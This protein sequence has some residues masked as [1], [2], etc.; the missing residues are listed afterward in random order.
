MLMISLIWLNCTGENEHSI[1]AVNS[2]ETFRDVYRTADDLIGQIT[3]GF[4][5]YGNN[6]N[7]VPLSSLKHHRDILDKQID[8]FESIESTFLKFSN[9]ETEEKERLDALRDSRHHFKT[10]SDEAEQTI[11]LLKEIA[12]KTEK[13]IDD[14]QNQFEP[15]KNLVHRRIESFK[16]NIENS[17]VFDLH[18]LLGSLTTLAF[19]Q[20]PAGIAIAGTEIVYDISENYQK[21]EDDR[22]YRVKKDYLLSKMQKL[23]G[24]IV[25][26][27]DLSEKTKKLNNG[28]IQI[29]K[30]GS[31]KLIVEEKNLSDFLDQFSYKFPETSESL[32]QA[33]MDYVN[34]V[35]ARNEKI[36]YYNNV[37]TLIIKNYNTIENLNR[38]RSI[39]NEENLKRYSPSLPAF[40]TLMNNIYDIAQ[41]QVMERLYLTERAFLFWG[42][43][44]SKP[45]SKL[46]SGC[47]IPAINCALL[48]ESQSSI[49]SAYSDA[50]EI[51]GI[52]AQAFPAKKRA[53]KG[54]IWEL[55]KDQIN[56][57]IEGYQGEYSVMF[58]IPPVR[59]DSQKDSNPFT[60]LTNVRITKVRAWIDGATTSDNE[61]SVIISHTGKET[62]IDKRDYSFDFYHDPRKVIFKYN[63]QHG[64]IIEDGDIGHA[65]NDSNYALIGPFTFWEISIKAKDNKGM[66]LSKV[67]AIRIEF[68]GTNYTFN[69]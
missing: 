33:F 67:S 45:V 37:I 52:D 3:K 24:D 9:K 53:K 36:V 1:G 7:Y 39:L 20:N 34:L 6:H 59:K 57:F 12:Q 15:Q 49:L 23:E 54:I 62:I 21:I 14:F 19:L 30:P 48:K 29:D 10:A 69:N 56:T 58:K 66:D 32:K 40:T 68:Y 50:I 61:L 26:V 51:Y 17:V 13:N 35:L 60:P 41:A 43:S 55:T 38:E 47:D 63:T 65:E 18:S 11:S 42:L 22:G 44:Y 31:N 2:L 16:H 4:D 25:S 28:K 8:N 64:G 5:Y 46:F 27:S